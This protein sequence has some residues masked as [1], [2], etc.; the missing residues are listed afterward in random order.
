MRL[1]TFVYAAAAEDPAD[2]DSVAED[3]SAAAAAA[4]KASAEEAAAEEEVP[5]SLAHSLAEEQ[6]TPS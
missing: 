1:L 2:Y 4:E 3:N 6:V 5:P